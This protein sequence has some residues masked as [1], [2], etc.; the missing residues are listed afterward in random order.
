MIE[1]ANDYIC[2]NGED[3]CHDCDRA[4]SDCGCDSYDDNEDS[5]SIVSTDDDE[6]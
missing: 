2:D 6:D 1:E 3:W 5:P 4:V